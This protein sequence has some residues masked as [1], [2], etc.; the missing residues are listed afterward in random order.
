MNYIE[1][2]NLANRTFKSLYEENSNARHM[3]MGVITEIG[4]IIDIYKKN[5][6][7]DKPIDEVNLSEEWAD[8]AWYLA[9]EA[10]R[11]GVL[12]NFEDYHLAEHYVNCPIEEILM[13]VVISFKQMQ[14]IRIKTNYN[15]TITSNN[16]NALFNHWVYIG[17]NVLEINTDKALQNNI[18]KLRVRYPDKF[19]EK[20]A[21][22]RDLD[23]ERREL[24]K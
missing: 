6:A 5:L 10:C 7:Y 18:D 13:D 3:M 17:E 4:E 22:N 16:L 12:L 19:T 8:V 14:Q 2:Q 15:K 11:T 21:L 23:S 1:Y 20:A 9:N 24:E